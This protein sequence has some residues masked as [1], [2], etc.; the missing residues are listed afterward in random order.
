MYKVSFQTNCYAWVPKGYTGLYPGGEN[1]LDYSLRSLA[2][3]GYDGVEVDCVH[4]LDTRLWMTSKEQRSLLKKAIADLGIEVEALSAHEWPL[5]YASFTSVDEESSKLGMEWTKGIID[6]ASDFGTRIVT[7]HVPNPQIRAL[8]LLPGMPR[9]FLRGIGERG[10]IF[11]KP[12]VYTEEERGLMIQRVGECADYSKDRDVIFAI[13]EYS[14]VN[15]W[16]DFIKAVGSSALKIN[17]HVGRVWTET[18]AT[19]GVIEEPSLPEAVREF[20]SLIVHTHCMDY[21]IVSSMPPFTGQTTRPTIEVIPGAGECDYIAFI[22]A[23]K[24]IGY[25][26]YLTVECHRSDIPP[27]IQASQALQNMRRMISQATI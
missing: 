25:E 20:G 2:K 6:L 16:K 17:L 8:K 1:T 24:E 22:K 15:F 10:P 3:I 7:T 11:G 9:G 23:L 27:E 12:R 4:I 13:E 19:K 5:P 18:Y 14:P 26:G 21:R